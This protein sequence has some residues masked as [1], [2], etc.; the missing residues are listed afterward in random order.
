MEGR[1]EISDEEYDVEVLEDGT[2]EIDPPSTGRLR[3]L[4]EEWTDDDEEEAAKDVAPVDSALDNDDYML[5]DNN[6]TGRAH[7]KHKRRG[8]LASQRL[9]HEQIGLEVDQASHSSEDDV[10]EENHLDHDAVM[11]LPGFEEGALL[12]ALGHLIEHKE[13]GITFAQMTEKRRL[14]WVKSFLAKHYYN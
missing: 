5:Q 3:N 6:I 2:V 9:K 14:R 11:N 7:R 8:I 10:A 4:M 12:A 13:M 1:T